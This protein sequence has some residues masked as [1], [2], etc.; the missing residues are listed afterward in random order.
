MSGYHF[1]LPSNFCFLVSF[2]DELEFGRIKILLYVLIR[3]VEFTIDPS[4]VVEKRVK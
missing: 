2:V 4:L 1:V 3:D